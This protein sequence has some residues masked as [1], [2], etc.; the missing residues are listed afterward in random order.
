MISYIKEVNINDL[1]A[2]LV[3]KVYTRLCIN[4]LPENI[5]QYNIYNKKDIQHIL[6]NFKYVP[7][8]PY[9]NLDTKS[10]INYMKSAGEHA[11]YGIEH[12][13]K[14][15]NN[16]IKNF[17]YLEPPYQ[18]DYITCKIMFN[19]LVIID[20]LHRASILKHFNNNTI[21]IKIISKNCN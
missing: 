11:G 9:I 17:K 10:Y 6:C 1:H 4:I 5:I 18:S 16:L 15:F 7:H 19:K 2:I 14:D 21:K 12:S 20:G 13:F 3:Y 8:I